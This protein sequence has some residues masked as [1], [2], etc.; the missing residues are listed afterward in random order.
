MVKSRLRP[1]IAAVLAG[2]LLAAG[3]TASAAAQPA[4]PN[5]EGVWKIAAPTNTLKPV[6]GSVPF[7]E[8]GRKQ[9]DENKRLQ[10]KGADAGLL[11]NRKT[12]L[13]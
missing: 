3:I 5:L 1:P 13:G 8:E 12:E 4:T 10:A 2:A 9:Y 11:P 6:G 7:T